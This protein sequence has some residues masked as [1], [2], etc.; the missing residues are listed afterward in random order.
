MSSNQEKELAPSADAAL[1]DRIS[2]ACKTLGLG[3]SATRGEIE[4]R[5]RTLLKRWHPDHNRDDP[6][7]SKSRTRDIL[8]AGKIIRTYCDNYRFSFSKEETDNYL[9]PREWW[10]KR[11]GM[12]PSGRGTDKPPDWL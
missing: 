11:F 10:C 5:I 12:D 7:R 6:E 2:W 8:E 4:G 1:F 9:S 3:S